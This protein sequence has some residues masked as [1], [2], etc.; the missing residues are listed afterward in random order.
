MNKG[1][2]PPPSQNTSQSCCGDGWVLYRS[3][4][5][6][7]ISRGKVGGFISIFTLLIILGVVGVGV[8]G[9]V[10]IVKTGNDKN[11]MASI[12]EETEIVASEN[13]EA[14]SLPVSSKLV[15]S[16][17]QGIQ[18]PNTTPSVDTT[19]L[20]LERE[21]S[22]L[23]DAKV[24]IG[25]EHYLL[26]LKNLDNAEKEGGNKDTVARLRNML[27]TIHS[28]ASLSAPEESQITTTAEEAPMPKG[29][30]VPTS[31]EASVGEKTEPVSCANDT[32]PKL[33]ADI[34][35]FSKIRKIT[36]PGNASVEGPK[37]HSFIWTG[38]A[39]VPIYAPANITLESGS[40]SKDTESSPAQYLLFF[41]V[42]ENCNYRVK[43]DHIDEPITSIREQF[44]AT[45]A[46]ADSHT[47]E[48]VNKIKFNTGDLIG[49]TSGTVSA[50]NWDFGMYN[51]NEEGP[52]KRVDNVFGIHGY[53]V[54]WVD[55]YSP[56]VKKYQYRNLLEG[57]TLVCFF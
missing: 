46:V 31:P 12:E 24:A 7:P 20:N 30:G 34:T 1:F 54:C 39:R 50:G 35:D 33:T 47:S 27:E 45:P 48:V 5:K 9:A 19:L 8:V 17:E 42:Q 6:G 43:F 56:D 53:S 3:F 25:E 29:V 40:Y 37:G 55:F 49:Y 44:S 41:V 22:V 21:I 38:G 36:A 15:K 57:T 28:Y 32:R 10:L 23:F 16:T 26:I 4:L 52:L 14:T 51:L 18:A 11:D 13:K 2:I